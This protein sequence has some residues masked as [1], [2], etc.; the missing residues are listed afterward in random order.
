MSSVR[1]NSCRIEREC[2]LIKSLLVGFSVI[3]FLAQGAAPQTPPQKNSYES[4][5]ARVKNNDQSVDFKELR[6]AF[7]NTPAYSPYGGDLDSRKQMFAALQAKEFEKVLENAEK[8][9]SKNYL[10]INGHFGAMVAHRELGHADKAAYH[11]FVCDGLLNS[12]K[13]SGDG[14]STDT[15]FVVISTD[16]EYVLFNWLGLR[17]TGQ[18]LVNDKG[19][20]YDRMTV[21]EPKTNQTL[22]FYFNIDKPFNWLGN[23]LKN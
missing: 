16:E 14:K 11:R 8:I 4:L 5:L 22:T 19:H 10:D 6:M 9:L 13:N 12:I 2:F 20:N 7:T 1:N 3:L 21:V 17:P 15:A 23:R 18:A